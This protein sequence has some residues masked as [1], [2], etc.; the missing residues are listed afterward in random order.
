MQ[1]QEKYLKR[2]TDK[3]TVRATVHRTT[4]R[5]IAETLFAWRP[6]RIQWMRADTLAMLLTMANIGAHGRALIL[7]GCAGLVTGAVAE[8]MGG[9][10]QVGNL[11]WLLPLPEQ[12]QCSLCLLPGRLAS[13]WQTVPCATDTMKTSKAL[14]MMW[15]C[16]A[17]GT[18]LLHAKPQG[19]LCAGVLGVHRAQGPSDRVCALLQLPAGGQGQHQE[20]S[21]GRASCTQ[22]AVQ[23]RRCSQR[24]P[25]ALPKRL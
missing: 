14:L 19:K 15:L 6:E 2:K 16:G 21:P 24:G 4:T 17:R 3:Y 13:S 20:P 7:D 12:Q 1:T 11:K 25:L 5:S 18:T 23:R 22:A 8:R 10:G 9:F